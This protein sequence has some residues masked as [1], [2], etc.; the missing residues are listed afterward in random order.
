MKG[1]AGA[2]DGSVG[3]TGLA[4]AQEAFDVVWADLEPGL[5]ESL[6]E[7]AKQRVAESVMSAVV[8]GERDIEA[9][10]KIALAA[11]KE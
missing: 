10:K 6:K 4:K 2:G 11:L 7:A 1:A 8:K 5:P 9:L 3:P